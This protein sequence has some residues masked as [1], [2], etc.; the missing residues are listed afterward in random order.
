MSAPLSRLACRLALPWGLVGALVAFAAA[1]AWAV[2]PK[3]GHYT[4]FV[5]PFQMSFT[6]AHGK[7]SQFVTNFEATECQG[8]APAPKSPFFQFPSVKIRDGR[9]SDSTTLHFK[10]GLDP[11]FTIAGSFTK[12]KHAAGTLHEH[13]AVPPSWGVP[14]CT[15]SQPFSLTLATK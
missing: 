15:L 2:T 14:S 12:P 4:G 3:N 8:L 11:H 10:S 7:I 5:D 9:F 13:I 1:P 6:V